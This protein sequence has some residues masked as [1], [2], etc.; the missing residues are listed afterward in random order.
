MLDSLC[1]EKRNRINGEVKKY[2]DF[3]ITY[4]INVEVFKH[5]NRIRHLL[6][7]WNLYEFHPY[8]KLLLIKKT[9]VLN[10][11]DL[12]SN[13]ISFTHYWNRWTYWEWV[14]FSHWAN[15][16]VSKWVIADRHRR[17]ECGQAR[18]QQRALASHTLIPFTL[19][20]FYFPKY[21]INI[22]LISMNVTYVYPFELRE[23]ILLGK[24]K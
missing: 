6:W 20:V 2:F 14:I 11:N 13:A 8:K 10:I 15:K 17:A 3:I 12:K 21:L 24:S 5:S 9:Y 16:L 4:S 7:T 18:I 22:T 23:K 1:C 19:P